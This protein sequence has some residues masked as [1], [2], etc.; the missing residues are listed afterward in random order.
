VHDGD[1]T[2][3]WHPDLAAVQVG[4][5]WIQL[6]LIKAQKIGAFIVIFGSDPTSEYKLLANT[7]GNPTLDELVNHYD[8]RCSSGRSDRHVVARNTR[9]LRLQFGSSSSCGS[10]LEIAELQVL[11]AEVSD[12]HLPRPCVVGIAEAVR[13]AG[14]IAGNAV[15]TACQTAWFGATEQVASSDACAGAEVDAN[16]QAFT[17]PSFV[18]C[19]YEVFN[20]FPSYYLCSPP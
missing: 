18:N 3:V 19:R 15:G 2:T 17:S 5:A 8:N 6:D 12:C 14:G 10:N 4:T 7:P 20:A 11:P 13:V 1:L 9:I 16:G